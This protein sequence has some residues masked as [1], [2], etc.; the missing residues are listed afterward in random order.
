MKKTP[1]QAARIDKAPIARQ[2]APVDKA[3]PAFDL[4]W[5][6]PHL[7]RRAHFD[8]EACFT[9]VYGNAATSRQLAL[10]VALAQAPGATQVEIARVIGLDANTCSDLVRRTCAKGLITRSR[11]QHDGRAYT[12]DLT[13]A[14]RA[15]VTDCALPLAQPY[16]ARISERL[17]PAQRQELA[18]LLRLMLGI[19]V[20]ASRG[21]AKE[22][23]DP[24]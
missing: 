24:Q 4:S 14:G 7:L 17:T 3:M 13:E 18:R 2:R 22:S 8:A 9:E 6:L 5:H 20:P 21:R 1:A 12:L 10:L 23:S 15:L 16:S 19:H 11:G